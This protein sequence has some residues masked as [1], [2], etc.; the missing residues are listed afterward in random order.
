MAETT[1]DTP[2]RFPKT[3]VG[4]IIIDLRSVFEVFPPKYFH[5]VQA[6]S[7][8]ERVEECLAFMREKILGKTS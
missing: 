7:T 5:S 3:G 1:N 8:D 6:K 4:V 2:V